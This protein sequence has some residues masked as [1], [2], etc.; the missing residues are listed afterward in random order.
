MLLFFFYVPVGGVSIQTLVIDNKVLSPSTRRTKKYVYQ[1][2]L[3]NLSK[4]RDRDVGMGVGMN[5]T[6]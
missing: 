4:C 1:L 2:D 5:L 3:P 6:L